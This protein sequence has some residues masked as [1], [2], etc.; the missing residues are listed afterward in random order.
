MVV[1]VR[2]EKKVKLIFF[3]FEGFLDWDF[4][5]LLFYDFLKFLSF[6]LLSDLVLGDDNV[7]KNVIL[8]VLIIC[9]WC[10]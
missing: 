8:E 10:G 6:F 1:M 7:K 5:W 2:E 4:D 9:L 3:I